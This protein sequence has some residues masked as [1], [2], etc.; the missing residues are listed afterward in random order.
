M[1]Y[2]HISMVPEVPYFIHVYIKM[3]SNSEIVRCVEEPAIW[4][5]H[6]KQ[7]TL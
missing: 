2:I 5:L 1:L 4:V 7:R 3:C 6:V